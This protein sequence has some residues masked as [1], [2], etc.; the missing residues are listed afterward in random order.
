MLLIFSYQLKGCGRAPRFQTRDPSASPRA[1]SGTSS[2]RAE[3]V[4]LAL[5]CSLW[6]SFEQAFEFFLELADVLEVAVDGGEA[7]VGDG[8]EA[9]EVIHDEFAHLRCGA[10]AL[11][12]VDQK[13]LGGVDDR[14]ELA[15][16]DWTFF[17]GTEQAAQ[18]FLPVEA[19]TAAILLDHHVGNF[20]DALVGGEAPIA[21]LALAA[22]PDRVGFFAFTRVDDPILP[23]STI[24][25]LHAE[26]DSTVSIR[27]Q[28][29]EGTATRRVP[30][31]SC[32]QRLVRPSSESMK[33]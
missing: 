2:E 1:G 20:V 31:S 12:R 9:L 3:A 30:G 29:T 27:D 10:L 32:L 23:K 5:R 19:L 8:V 28:G 17:A 16:R 22:P 24:W 14:F 25:T 6:P 13:A 21:A 26:D 11:G 33:D 18:N 4:L 15:R 7:D